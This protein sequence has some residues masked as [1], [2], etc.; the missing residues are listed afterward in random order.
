MKVQMFKMPFKTKLFNENQKVWIKATSGSMAAFV[1]GKHH[2][3]GRYISAW[4]NWAA[5]DRKNPE[6]KELEVSDQF[7][8]SHGIQEV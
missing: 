6:F 8:L 7:A 4:V 1:T 5:T 2:G 3:S